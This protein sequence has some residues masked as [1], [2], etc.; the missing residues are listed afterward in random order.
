MTNYSTQ[1]DKSIEELNELLNEIRNINCNIIDEYEA[2]ITTNKNNNNILKK[3]NK[4]VKELYIRTAVFITS[5]SLCASLGTYVF[6]KIEKDYYENIKYPVTTYTF[7]EN[8]KPTIKFEF[9]ESSDEFYDKV[10][11]KVY[12]PFNSYGIRNIK[13]YDVTGLNYANV[14]DYFEY[15]LNEYASNPDVEQ[16]VLKN[17]NNISNEE[18]KTVIIE[19]IDE[20]KLDEFKNYAKKEAIVQSI[21]PLY[22][23]LLL[24]ITDIK[25][26]NVLILGQFKGL[27]NIFYDLIENKHVGCYY[28]VCDTNR[29]LEEHNKL[30]KLIRSN[31]T[32]NQ[33]F[34]E[35]YEAYKDK[36][37]DP[38]IIIED[39]KNIN[40][41]IDKNTII[42]ESKRGLK[43]SRKLEKINKQN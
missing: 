2:I 23:A 12:E 35:I 15:D 28:P 8:V 14:E 31:E 40:D 27:I 11:I 18:V 20:E 6:K 24:L 7:Q 19:N 17:I 41:M 25:S 21:L 38:Y 33:K 32:L 43:I 36:M 16:E 13:T 4:K 9:K 22:I 10:Y 30:L 1:D 42:D 39:L 37:N 26:K 3:Y 34:N 5:L 29:L